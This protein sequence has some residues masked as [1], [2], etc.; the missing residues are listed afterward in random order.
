[1]S[2][3]ESPLE[4]VR[5]ESRACHQPACNAQR[6]CQEIALPPA[7]AVKLHR[8]GWLSFDPASPEPLDEARAAEL[9]FV[10]TLVAAGCS[11]PVLRRLLA[12]LR[13]PYSYDLRRMF[14]DWRS[15]QWRTLPGEE[16]P[17]GAFFALLER[18]RE[19]RAGD[20]IFTLREWLDEALDLVRERA[21]LLSHSEWTRPHAG[22]GGGPAFRRG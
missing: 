11:R 10:G 21:D 4:S 5:I 19:R 15:G 18:L 2:A 6:M 9:A 7:V 13:R 1:M 3:T 12:G 17:E 22:D 8:E 16:D 14:F 20:V